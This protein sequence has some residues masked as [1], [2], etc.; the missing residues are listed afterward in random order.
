MHISNKYLYEDTNQEL[1]FYQKYKKYKVKY[2][3]LLTKINSKN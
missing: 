1:Q 2:L 3:N